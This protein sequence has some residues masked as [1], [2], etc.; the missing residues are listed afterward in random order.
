MCHGFGQL[1]RDF[2][3][4]FEPIAGNGRA[5]VAPEALS[6]F[7]RSQGTVHSAVTPVGATWM[8]SEDRENEIA[9]Y[10]G[11]LDGLATEVSGLISP[12]A[13][14]TVLGFSQGAATASRWVA[15][16]TQTIS[17]VILWGGMLPP[18]LRNRDKI[19]GLSKQPLQF[20]VGSSDRYFKPELVSTE[21]QTLK[22]L[23]IDASLVS[24][25]GGHVIEP[26]TLLGLV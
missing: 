16:S 18:E 24:F 1:A 10:I 6:R 21:F 17:R 3:V 26:A 15:S 20:V 8:T 19:G 13:R 14:T 12:G 4:D 7:Y 22:D 11:Y 25:D 5:I 23:G 9:D 2:L